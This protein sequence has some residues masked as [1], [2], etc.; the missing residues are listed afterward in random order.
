MRR[1]T[2]RLSYCKINKSGS[3]TAVRLLFYGI[4]DPL[5][6]SKSLINL[7]SVTPL[8]AIEA[9]SHLVPL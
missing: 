7:Y 3:Q 6:D 9:E 8:W 1:S 4:K 5:R 2:S